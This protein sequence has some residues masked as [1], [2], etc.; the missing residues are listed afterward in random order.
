[1]DNTQAFGTYG[2]TGGTCSGGKWVNNRTTF[3]WNATGIV[4]TYADTPKRMIAVHELGHALGLGHVA[5][6]PAP[7]TCTQNK[8]VMR[9]G[10]TK[11]TCGWTSEPWPDDISGVNA[12]Y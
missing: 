1:V 3:Y 9:Q 11:W 12:I 2:Y 7:A 8:A 10:E 5:V 6:P 4:S